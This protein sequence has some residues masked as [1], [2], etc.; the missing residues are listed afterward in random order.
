MCLDRAQ[1]AT[2]GRLN[3]DGVW[4]SSIATESDND[5]E[6]T[7]ASEWIRFV[8]CNNQDFCR[9][10]EEILPKVSSIRPG[11]VKRDH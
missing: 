7:S 8:I 9:A 2:E 3:S 4:I 11:Q 6:L 1:L 5:I 10:S